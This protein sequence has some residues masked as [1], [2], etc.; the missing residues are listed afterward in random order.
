MNFFK[1]FYFILLYVHQVSFA[2]NYHNTKEDTLPLVLRVI[3]NTETAYAFPHPT[4]L[5]DFPCSQNTQS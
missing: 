5:R 4:A 3:L 1:S 2:T